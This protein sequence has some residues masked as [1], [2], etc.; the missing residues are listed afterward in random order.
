MRVCQRNDTALH[1]RN[2]IHK[3]PFVAVL[4]SVVFRRQVLRRDNFPAHTCLRLV[5]GAECVG[6]ISRMQGVDFGNYR[7]NQE[8][9]LV[10]L[11]GGIDG[12]LID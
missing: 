4:S 5:G 8:D 6:G 12:V 9:S 11:F 10:A 3:R 2:L 1:V 7:C